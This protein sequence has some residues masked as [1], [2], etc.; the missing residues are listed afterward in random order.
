VRLAE[1]GYLN[2]LKRLELKKIGLSLQFFGYVFQQ[3]PKLIELK[4]TAS[5]C[6]MDD[7]IKNQLQP[8]FQKLQR[9]HLGWKVNNP[10]LVMQEVL[11]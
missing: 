10:W 1:K 11:T 9:L 5:D 6:F 8:V 2:N 7:E 4:I 3:C